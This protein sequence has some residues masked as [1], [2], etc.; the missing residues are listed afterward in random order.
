MEKMTKNAD[1][2]IAEDAIENAKEKGVEYWKMVKDKGQELWNEAESNTQNTWGK[3]KGYIQKNPV[4]A[5][6]L[7]ALCGV[8]AAAL[9]YPRKRS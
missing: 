5:I 6:G 8:L 4:K 9:F 3:T 7:A 1:G 2:N